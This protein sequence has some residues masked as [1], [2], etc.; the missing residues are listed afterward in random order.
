VPFLLA[1]WE[2]IAIAAHSSKDRGLAANNGDVC[3][4][5]DPEWQAVETNE[6]PKLDDRMG[7]VPAAAP[8]PGGKMP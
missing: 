6:K 8:W 7:N 2:P 1:L 3:N 4:G 5:G